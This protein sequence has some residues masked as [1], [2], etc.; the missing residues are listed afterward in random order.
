MIPFA[1]VYHQ[2]DIRIH[3][4]RSAITATIFAYLASEAFARVLIAGC[5]AKVTA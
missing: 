2:W 1:T 3:T 5:T 4:S